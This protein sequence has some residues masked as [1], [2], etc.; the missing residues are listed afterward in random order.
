MALP[1]MRTL[2][3]VAVVALQGIVVAPTVQAAAADLAPP[4]SITVCRV[5]YGD[6]EAVTVPFDQYVRD[7]LPQEFGSSG[8]RAYL[9]AGA[10]AVKS[11]AWYH[12][13]N[14]ASSR[15]DL[16]DGARHQHYRPD[17]GLQPT[18]QTDG[19]VA[20]TWGLRLDAGGRPVLA[21]YC[22][23]SCELFTP[24]RHLDQ[25]EAKAQARRGQTLEQIIGHAYR[26]VDGLRLRAWRDGFGIDLTG[27]RPY[28]LDGDGG[29]QIGAAVTG[30]APGDER[31]AVRFVADCTID[32]DA[33]T[34]DVQTVPVG[35]GPDG[36]AH[37]VLD[38]T[39]TIRRCQEDRVPV[40][41]VLEVNGYGVAS[42]RA[43]A[44]RPWRSAEPRPVRRLAA[45]DDPVD[46]AIALSRQLFTEATAGAGAG[47]LGGLV[48]GLLGGE[49][50]D[51]SAAQG[52]GTGGRRAAQSVVLARAERFA[53]A[54]SATGLAGTRA[55]ILFN[56]GGQGAR[57]D[58]AVAAEVDRV[59]GGTGV[60]HLVGGDA[61]L[62]AA[63]AS[64]LADRGYTVRRHGGPTRVETALAVADALVARRGEPQGVMVARAYPDS[65]AGWADA[66]TG[67]AYAAARSHPVLLTAPDRLDDAVEAWIEDSGTTEAILLGGPSAISPDAPQ[68]LEVDRVTRVAGAARDATA[69]AV[70]DR[71]WSR[72]GAPPV[73]SV[74]LVDTYADR[75]WPFALAA[76]VYGAVRGAP[77]LA[78]G[79]VVPRATTGAWLDAHPDLPAVVVGGEGI[80]A[81]RID[82]DAA[83]RAS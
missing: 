70:A 16:T 79:Q 45:T 56:P 49:R 73:T 62:P 76:A 48:G 8:P 23:R 65:S 66:V 55:P 83:G 59:L 7:V 74:V 30:V 67:G 22:S 82:G 36:T 80:V 40:T 50:A 39:G 77:Q 37:A 52:G 2:V 81:P 4:A 57:L 1:P 54:L 69:V 25:R 18:A 43:T 68:R 28:V 41:A 11:Y 61:A 9:Q 33:G 58:E 42:D 12:V 21:Q 10:V 5:T 72:S 3:A 6:G 63:I 13:L 15:C 75:A 20:A 60:V 46:G 71:L 35:T 31:A 29:P 34:H 17:G 51:G 32:G 27:P 64:D 24:G 78:V 38:D 14:P 53:D 47:G 19:A 26:A 44:V